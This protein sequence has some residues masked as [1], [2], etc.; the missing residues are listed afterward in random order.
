MRGVLILALGH[1]YYGR[2]AHNLAMSLRFTSP[3]LK[4]TLAYADEALNHYTDSMRDIFDNI[5]HVDPVHYTKFGQ[6]EY[7]K[8]KTAIYELSPYSETIFLDAD[9][10]WLPK[11]PIDNLFEEL[12]DIDF[13]I[14]N[15]S[16]IDVSTEYE[17]DVSIWCDLKELCEAYGINEGK[18][19]H[20]N[21][22]VIYFKKNKQVRKIFKDAVRH[23]DSLRIMCKDFANGIPDELVFSLSMMLNNKY[24]HVDRWVPIYWEDAEK[25]NMEP[26]EMHDKYYGYSAGGR[27]SS[28]TIKSFYNNLITFYG[29]HFG[30]QYPFMLKDKSS[31]LPERTHV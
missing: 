2:L 1:P 22:E 9:M 21:S 19:F 25:A 7:I 14:Q 12:K 5:I 8:A 16:F 6:V 26:R 31:Y 13:T 23:Y 3:K 15:R 10:L 4:I 28:N 29:N 24:P 20:L 18:Y 30:V 27:A 11:K 17:Q